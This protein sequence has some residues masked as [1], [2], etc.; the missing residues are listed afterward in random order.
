M[1]SKI[2]IL[3]LTISF[4]FVLLKKQSEDRKIL[5]LQENIETTTVYKDLK[6]QLETW[7][8]RFHFIEPRLHLRLNRSTEGF[9]SR[10][11]ITIL[12]TIEDATQR[13]SFLKSILA[14]EF[15]HYYISIKHPEIDPGPEQELLADTIAQELVG[16]SY[17]ELLL[18]YPKEEDHMHPSSSARIQ[19]LQHIKKQVLNK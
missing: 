16:Q 7:S 8:L 6:D 12:T 19:N 3:I 15:A 11:L 1:K 5:N 14:H 9:Y 17:Q 13:S 4:S 10:G 18:A 2:I